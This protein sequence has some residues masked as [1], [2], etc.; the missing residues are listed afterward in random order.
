MPRLVC[1]DVTSRFI[2]TNDLHSGDSSAE[3]CKAA[4]QQQ[5][6][7][8]QYQQQGL[9][10]ELQSKVTHLNREVLDWFHQL[11]PRLKIRIGIEV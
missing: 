2:Y 10:R 8:H 4:Q 3:A 1:D 7:A 5:E 6:A 9:V 11:H